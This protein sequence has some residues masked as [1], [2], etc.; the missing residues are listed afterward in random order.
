MNL[1]EHLKWLG[2]K[3]KD[4]VS[5]IEGTVHSVCFDLFGCIQADVRPSGLNDDGKMK[6]GWWM[7]VTRLEATQ[8]NPV[9][10]MPNFREGYVSTGRKGASDKSPRA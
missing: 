10:E 1:E 7:D 4:K 3:V 6:N 5:G 8:K 9:M 2:M